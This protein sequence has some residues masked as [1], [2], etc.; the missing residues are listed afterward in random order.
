MQETQD[1]AVKHVS[2]LCRLLSG[3]KLSILVVLKHSGRVFDCE[4]LRKRNWSWLNK[5]WYWVEISWISLQNWGFLPFQSSKI[6]QS[7]N[8]STYRIS[9]EIGPGVLLENKNQ[10]SHCS[11]CQFH[12]CSTN[13]NSKKKLKNIE[14]VKKSIFR[15]WLMGF[16]YAVTLKI[17]LLVR[18]GT[19]KTILRRP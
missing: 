16:T 7:E 1:F 13:W 2:S 10:I 5:T 11:K 18:G 9:I 15:W 6:R 8:R 17:V 3:R 14:D 19:R 4:G 12:R